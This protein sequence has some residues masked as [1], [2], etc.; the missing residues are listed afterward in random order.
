MSRSTKRPYV[1]HAGTHE[2]KSLASR[3]FRRVVKQIL[4]PWKYKYYYR[5]ES[6]CFGCECEEWGH[7]CPFIFYELEPEFPHSKWFTNPY[8]IRDFRFYSPLDEGAYR[9]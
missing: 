8:D 6:K 5:T 4:S 3:R 7:I 1:S 9:K 2:S